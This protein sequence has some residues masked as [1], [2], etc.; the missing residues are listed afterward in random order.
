MAIGARTPVHNLGCDHIH[1]GLPRNTSNTIESAPILLPHH[2]AGGPRM[3]HRK[4][5]CA[6]S[7]SAT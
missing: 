5:H 6:S 3:H 4:K 2:A 1:E 7:K